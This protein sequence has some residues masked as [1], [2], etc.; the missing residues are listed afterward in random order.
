MAY[1]IP[2]GKLTLELGD[3]TGITE[4]EDLE[5]RFGKVHTAGAQ[6]C[7]AAGELAQFI[8]HGG[9]NETPAVGDEL[10]LQCGGVAKVIIGTGGLTAGGAV[11]TDATGAAVA[12]AATNEIL[13][14]C[15]VGGAAGEVGSVLL[16]YSGT[17]A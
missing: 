9:V 6:R 14:H 16:G 17:Q 1:E 13:G 10:T 5:Y 12:A 2:W 8:I 7:D 4:A 3:I 11:T 15:V